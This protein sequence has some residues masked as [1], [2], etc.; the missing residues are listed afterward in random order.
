M[1]LIK[2][3]ECGKEFSDKANACPNCA[4]PVD[5]NKKNKNQPKQ[6]SKNKFCIIYYIVLVISIIIFTSLVFYFSS[7]LLLKNVIVFIISSL[8]LLLISIFNII[9]GKKIKVW[10]KLVILGVIMLIPLIVLILLSNKSTVW[11]YD[12]TK[13]NSSEGVGLKMTVVGKC[14][15]YYNY[16]YYLGDKS[17]TEH[18]NSKDCSWEKNGNKYTFFI[19]YQNS[20]NIDSFDCD[21]IDGTLKCPIAATPYSGRYITLKRMY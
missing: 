12:Y 9:I 5:Y 13:N 3:E 2:C 4:C 19:V 6:K 21:Y 18:T 17:V 8:Y 14:D 7:L 15:F 16:F 11:H 10:K 20:E 1:A